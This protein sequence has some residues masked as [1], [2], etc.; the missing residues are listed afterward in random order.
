MRWFIMQAKVGHHARF[1]AALQSLRGKE[2]DISL[3]AE[4]IKVLYICSC[5]SKLLN[6]HI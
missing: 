6:M 3:E 2:T 5:E 4:E 1:E